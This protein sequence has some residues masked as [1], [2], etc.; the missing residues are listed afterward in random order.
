M[1]RNGVTISA[2]SRTSSSSY[3]VDGTFRSLVLTIGAFK[4]VMEPY[5]ARFGIGGSQWGVL[6]NLYRAE[7][8][9]VPSLRLT[10]LSGRLIIRPPSVTEV[11]NRLQR[12][13]LVKR[14]EVSGD[15][16]AKHVCLTRAG[17]KLV[18]RVLGR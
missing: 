10:D 11:V 3:A 7:E 5:F 18:R 14:A 9:G 1:P 8:E 6:R 15:Q 13:G 4:R 17:R 2:R 12:M 16:R